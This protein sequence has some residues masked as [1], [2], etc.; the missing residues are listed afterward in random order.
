VS[1][2]TVRARVDP[3]AAVRTVPAWAWLAGLVVVSTVVR[4][5]LGRRT[6]APWI[7]VDEL[8]Y[9]EL[10]K[11]FAERG[12]LLVRDTQEGSGFGV[13]YPIL[14]SP[15]YALF[16]SVPA[17]Y[18][19]AKAINALLMSLA[20]VPVYLLARRVLSQPGA[21]AAAV[22]ALALPSL[23]Y[24]SMLMTENAFYPLFLTAALLLVLVLER[25]TPLRTLAFLGL[26][27]A[28]YL[29]RAQ[30]ALLVPALLTAPLVLV[31]LERRPRRLWD[32]R[33]VYAVPAGALVTL[34]AL[35]AAR[36]RSPES[37]LGAYSAASDSSY[38]L[39][40]ASRWLLWHV[41]ELELSV[42]VVPFAALLLLLAIPGRLRERDL[43]FLA[44]AFAL[45]LWV[46]VVVA[47]FASRHSGRIEERNMF[48]VVP[49]LAIALLLW[50][51]RGAPRPWRFAV[52][53]GAVAA[54]LPA[55]IPFADL[56]GVSAV[57][58]TFG[59][60]TWWEVHHWGVPLDRVWVAAVAASVAAVALWLLVPARYATVLPALLLVFLLAAGK[61]VE[62]RIRVA[63]IGELF[64]GITR[65]ERDWVDRAVGRDGAVAALWSG[66]ADHRTI[67]E[68]EFFSRSIGPVYT[69]A[70]PLP[71]G[72][73][74]TPLASDEETGRLLDPEGRAVQ[75]EHAFVDE[76]VP[77]AGSVVARDERKGTRVLRVRGD[78]RL[79]YTVDGAYDDGWSG[80]ELTYTR[81]DCGGGTLLVAMESDPKLFAVSQTATA[82]VGGRAVDSARIPRDGVGRLRV[83]LRGEGG[84]CVVRFR[85][86]PVAV[87]GA[88][89]ARPL[90][91]HFRSFE[92]RP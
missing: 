87:P 84:R 90:G 86:S 76:T 44:A 80:R 36:G 39:R 3:L 1:S 55:W 15:A 51:E 17:A 34:L 30:A 27:T 21:L 68:N 29:T 81:Y 26:V 6:V 49:L 42:G 37:L 46:V 25:P 8:I 10:A 33:W 61:P 14:I 83:P 56:I 50:I 20:A 75:A 60:L 40:Q 71:G 43:P 38:D 72:L 74:E 22:L 4:Y 62:K 35:Q 13:L 92:Y 41:A 32:F 28:C 7:F 31:A 88:G 54:V 47:V 2:T 48:Y 5:G 64:Q 57:S 66:R 73:V 85:V 52:P 78:L 70:G 77:L 19:A 23:F 45:S 9:S 91:T 79:A 65:P 11:S 67:F 18:A 89:D 12:E 58:D 69:L 16:D 82:L 24:A 63:S 59:L 53:A